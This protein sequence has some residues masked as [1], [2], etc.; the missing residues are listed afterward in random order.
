MIQEAVITPEYLRNLMNLILSPKVY[1]PILKIFLNNRKTPIV[2]PLFYENTLVKDFTRKVEL[3]NLFFAK[4][5]TVIN[6]DSSR[7]SSCLK[8]TRF[9]LM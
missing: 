9:C 5:C 1:L 4:R 8:Q 3:F 2:P 7:L 6:N